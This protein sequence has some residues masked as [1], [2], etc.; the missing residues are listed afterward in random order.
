MTR[1]EKHNESNPPKTI[2]VVVVDRFAGWQFDLLSASAIGRSGVPAVATTSNRE[3][4]L[5]LSG[6]LLD[7]RCGGNPD[8]NGDNEG[9]AVINSKPGVRCTA[10]DVSMLL[11]DVARRS[12]FAGGVVGAMHALARAGL[13]VVGRQANNGG[14]F[15]PVSDCGS[16]TIAP[17]QADISRASIP[18]PPDIMMS[19]A[20]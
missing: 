20:L 12:R 9:V 1:A 14:G 13:C 7:R 19:G 5:S 11:T 6:V 10:A 18:M 16:V 8:A 4:A 2:G 15:L 3:P 17:G